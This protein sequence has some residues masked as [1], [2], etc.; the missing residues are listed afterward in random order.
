MKYVDVTATPNPERTPSVFDALAGSEFVIESRLADWNLAVNPE[1]KSP[2]ATF[3]FDV[4]GDVD[5]FRDV[6]SGAEGVQRLD[7][8]AVGE[9]RFI[10]LLVLEPT[11]IQLM[12]EVFAA[13]TRTGLV[14]TTP[15][16]Y[17]DGCVQ[18]RAVGTAAAL[19]RAVSAFPADVTVD[20]DAVGEFDWS[21]ERSVS[22]LSDRQREA[23]LAALDL[24]YYETPRQA[25][26]E[27]VAAELDCA[28]N[29][30]SEHLQKAEATL[31][32]A[33]LDRSR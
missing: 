1:G 9:R 18:T 28:P 20:V 4:E 30:A 8:T 3:L 12:A 32:T 22:R 21:R 10:A 15:V 11:A 14:V 31:L 6:V 2:V 17:R 27:D 16:V 19:Q 25:T 24:G 33:V 29:T 7:A 26:H 23:V 5:R 13:M